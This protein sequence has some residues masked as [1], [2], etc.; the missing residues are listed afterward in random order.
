MKIENLKKIPAHYSFWKINFF[1]IISIMFFLI[2]TSSNIFS[3]TKKKNTLLLSG[4]EFV[5][6]SESESKISL[7]KKNSDENQNIKINPFYMSKHE[8][9]FTQYDLFCEKTKRKKPSDA[10]HAKGD[11]SKIGMEILTNAADFKWKRND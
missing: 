5:Y 4:V 10:L 1:W 8:V 9:T 3:I 7:N 2:V 6:I 11:W